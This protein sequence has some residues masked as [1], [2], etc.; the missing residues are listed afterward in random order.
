[1]GRLGVSGELLRQNIVT[2]PLTLQR[3][4]LQTWLVAPYKKPERDLANNEV[5]NNHVLMV[6]IHSEHA[7]GF[8]KGQFQSLKGLCIRIK[9]RKSHQ[10]TTYWIAACIGL[11]TFA[12]QWEAEECAAENSDDKDAVD[13][14]IAQGLSSDSDSDGHTNVGALARGPVSGL[15]LRQ[16]KARRE[17]L[18]QSLFR[19]KDRRR[20]RRE[21]Q[22]NSDYDM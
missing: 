22:E 3:I 20:R 19:A 16:A 1:L 18:K 17:Q 5:F 10:Y 4:Q 13:P 9:N 15:H 14:F 21:Q 12:M 6:R 2:K 8:L 11:H 7:I